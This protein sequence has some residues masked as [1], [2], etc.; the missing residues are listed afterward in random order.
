RCI[1]ALARECKHSCLTTERITTDPVQQLQSHR[2]TPGRCW[3]VA[4]HGRCCVLCLLG[5]QLAGCGPD[6]LPST[7]ICMVGVVYCVF[8]VC[9]WQCCAWCWPSRLPSTP[10]CN[11]AAAMVNSG[12]HCCC[13][14][15]VAIQAV[16]RYT[17]AVLLLLGPG[18]AVIRHDSSPAN[19]MKS[20][21]RCI[22]GM[23]AETAKQSRSGFLQRKPPT[24][25]Q[26]QHTI[27][28][29]IVQLGKQSSKQ[30]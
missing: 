26:L 30:V 22:A 16:Q 24:A 14:D 28:V 8:L 23:A 4:A 10:I 21:Y 20:M 11:Q 17:V 13:T 18:V 15:L 1:G 6:R 7:T 25:L 3:G 19:S 9:S 12:E 29:K 27:L 2:C 5:V